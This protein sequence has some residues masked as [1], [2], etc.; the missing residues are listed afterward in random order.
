VEA[1]PAGEQLAILEAM[2]PPLAPLL[3]HAL[4]MLAVVQGPA[5]VS[6]RCSLVSNLGFWIQARGR[7]HSCCTMRWPCWQWCRAPLR[8]ATGAASILVGSIVQIHVHNCCSTRRPCWRRCRAPLRPAA[9]AVF[10]LHSVV[11]TL[12][13]QKLTPLKLTHTFAHGKDSVPLVLGSDGM[14]LAYAAHQSSATMLYLLA[15]STW[16][17]QY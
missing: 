13:E 12:S 6:D 11:E 10:T 16:H 7:V 17:R 4:A 9:G 14:A 1:P 8:S 2:F 15:A 3:H 5:A